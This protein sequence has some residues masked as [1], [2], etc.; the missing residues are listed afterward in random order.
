[1]TDT[2][3]IVGRLLVCES[4]ARCRGCPMKY[5]EQAEQDLFIFRCAA[6]D[7]AREIR[8]LEHES[9]RWELE[10]EAFKNERDEFLRQAR[11][12]AKAWQSALA[13]LIRLKARA[14]P[15]PEGA[16]PPLPKT[17]EDDDNVRNDEGP[18]ER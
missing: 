15:A 12:L 17:K 18:G 14:V 11:E 5:E 9:R 13:D 10:A 4:P 1:M 6:A 7:A 8:R 2:E 3:D 16:L